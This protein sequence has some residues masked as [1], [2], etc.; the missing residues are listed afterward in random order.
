MWVLVLVAAIGALL[1]GLLSCG[2]RTAGPW[3][4]MEQCSDCRVFIRDTAT[5]AEQ[6]KQVPVDVARG[7]KVTAVP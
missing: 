2:C 5:T 1:V 6:G 3:V 4:R 7:A